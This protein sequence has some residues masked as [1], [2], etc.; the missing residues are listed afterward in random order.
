VNDELLTAQELADRLKRSESYVRA[1]KRSGFKMTGN[2]TTLAEARDWLRK[3]GGPKW[4]RY[5]DSKRS[6]NSA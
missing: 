3:H 6:R 5:G 1:L 4:K 2:R